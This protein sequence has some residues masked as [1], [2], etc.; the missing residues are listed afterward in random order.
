MA[1]GKI[2]VTVN[3]IGPASMSLT[4]TAAYGSNGTGNSATVET[5]PTTNFQGSQTVDSYNEQ[6]LMECYTPADLSEVPDGTLVTAQ[7]TD[8][9]SGA[10]LYLTPH[11]GSNPDTEDKYYPAYPTFANGVVTTEG[12]VYSDWYVVL[13]GRTTN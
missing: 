8:S 2:G 10:T 11:T 4:A 1:G 6:W 3:T 5:Q 9:A 7:F 13:Q 12:S